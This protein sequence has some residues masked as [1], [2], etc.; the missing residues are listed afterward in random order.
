MDLSN[1]LLI[2]KKPGN[3][4][5]PDQ[6]TIYQP[7]FDLSSPL[8]AVLQF[9]QFPVKRGISL[10]RIGLVSR[11]FLAACRRVKPGALVACNPEPLAMCLRIQPRG[12]PVSG[13]GFR[14][15][16]ADGCGRDDGAP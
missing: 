6:G 3:S 11:S 4:C 10:V 1:S 7:Q 9:R 12:G 2:T 15:R 5:P 14:P 13:E 16:D 8:L